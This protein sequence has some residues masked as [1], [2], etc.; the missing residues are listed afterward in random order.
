MRIT[1]VAFGL[2]CLLLG[3]RGL[4]VVA[5][6]QPKYGVTVRVSKAAALA[7]AKT[8]SWTAS[9]PS[10][11][12]TI[13]AQIVAAVDR[14]LGALGLTKVA[15]GNSDLVTTY[16]SVSRTDV[17]LKSEGVKTGQG[18]Q[19]AVGTLVVDL[20]DPATRQPLFRVRVDKPIDAEPDKLEAAINAAVTAMF[21]KYPTRTST[22]R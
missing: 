9:Q 18:R 1:R 3:V 15:S 14:E 16:A 10:P 21:E 11:I 4:V 22:K 7:K 2:T 12:K 6:Q 5:G 19:F 17:D 13:D 20:R 8:Y